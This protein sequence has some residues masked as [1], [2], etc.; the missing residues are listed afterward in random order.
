MS[1]GRIAAV[2]VVLAVGVVA[3]ILIAGDGDD[4]E[5]AGTTAATTTTGRDSTPFPPGRAF[6]EPPVIE[7]GDGPVELVARNGSIEVSGLKVDEAQ[8]YVRAGTRAGSRPGLLGPTL[9]VEPGETID[10]TLD[11][12]LEV[13]PAI[14]EGSNPNSAES[15]GGADKPL[16]PHSHD[17]PPD[18]G[19]QY[20][21]M[22]FHGLH[23]TPTTRRLPDGST[24]YGDNVL[25]SLPKGKSHIQFPVPKDHE[26][27]TF[28]YHAHRHGCT[29]DQVF[30]GLA[31]LLVVG[32]S[33]EELPARFREV[34][35]RSLALKDLQVERK[36][37]AHKIPANH[38]WIQT[39]N[40]TV[41]GVFQPRMTIEPRETQLWRL[42]NTSSAVW[43]DVALVDEQDDPDP[44]TI[45][46]QD[47]NTL[48]EAQREKSYA[49][50]P[51][52]RIDVLV[53]APDS[54]S[55]TLKTLAFDQGR[56][57]PGGGPTF[58][59]AV[60]A[61][62]EVGDDPAPEIDSPGTLLP[63]R[64]IP[65]RRGQSQ[66]LTFDFTPGPT[67]NGKP[68]DPDPDSAPLVEA[69]AETTQRW[70]LLNPTSEWHPIHVHQDDFRVISASAGVFFDGQ[71]DV[72]PLPPGT[73]DKPGKVVLDMPF[74][75]LDEG[76]FVVHCHI[77]D[78][79]DGG[80]MGRIDV[81]APA[82][83]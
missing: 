70:T 35:T 67:I 24:I 60:L 10:I 72:V 6:E 78:H 41:N 49:L 77:L 58:P 14:H 17:D 3:A 12:Q 16:D 66:T 18:S 44:L 37:G 42:A 38:D 68:F 80:M 82:P 57:G 39:T 52:Q 46:A 64:P 11:N 26:Q 19:P 61:T 71:Q 75:D 13:I 69:E 51:G 32:D 31:G 65:A 40:R 4:R 50:G 34:R 1:A 8:S 48:P 76:Q 81:S 25:V 33:R 5:E 47:G 21:N 7:V 73:K 45:V 56:P 53:R 55:R 27:G 30:R 54:G 15:C 29:D 36:G 59:E 43:Y 83:P 63:R 28:W 9:H 22:H 23:V 20:T 74:E 2:L 62:L 79:E